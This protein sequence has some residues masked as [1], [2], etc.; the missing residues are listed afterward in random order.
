MLEKKN[1]Y[2]ELIG[3]GSCFSE[4]GAP[5]R[6]RTTGGDAILRLR[7]ADQS[8]AE[9]ASGG[10]SDFSHPVTH[11]QPF[12]LSFLKKFENF[13]INSQ[14]IDSLRKFISYFTCIM[15]TMHISKFMKTPESVCLSRIALLD[16][17]SRIWDH[18]PLL[19]LLKP[20]PLGPGRRAG[21]KSICPVGG[22]G[23]HITIT[24]NFQP[25]HIRLNLEC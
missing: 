22:S 2:K 3:G 11:H 15:R 7:W 14:P 19:G 6:L 9:A 5:W 10:R 17:N 1:I 4:R 20:G 12:S 18:G 8:G 23:H 21:P 24:T 13:G 16:A 25:P